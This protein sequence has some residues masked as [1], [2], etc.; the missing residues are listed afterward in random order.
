MCVIKKQ[1]GLQITRNMTQFVIIRHPFERLVSGYKDKIENATKLYYFKIY[2]KNVIRKYRPLPRGVSR[3]M[4]RQNINN[5][6]YVYINS[7]IILHE[8]INLYLVFTLKQIKI[9][10]LSNS[11]Y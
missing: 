3:R 4:V 9:I 2:G 1:S 5:N 11:T 7:Y 8:I 10:I 6:D